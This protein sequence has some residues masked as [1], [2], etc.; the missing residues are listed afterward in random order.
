MKNP[1]LYYGNCKKP[2]EQVREGLFHLLDLDAL[3]VALCLL[4]FRRFSLSFRR[5]VCSGPGLVE[6][7]GERSVVLRPLF[8]PVVSALGLLGVQAAVDHGTARPRDHACGDPARPQPRHRGP[9]LPPLQVV[10]HRFHVREVAEEGRGLHPEDAVQFGVADALPVVRHQFPARRVVVPEGPLPLVEV[11]PGVAQ[12]HQGARLPVQA[13]HVQ[14]LQHGVGVAV[15]EPVVPLVL[16][17]RAVHPHR[18]D[19]VV[20]SLA[21]PQVPDHGFA[22]VHNVA[23][24]VVGVLEAQPVAAGVEAGDR[25]AA[26]L[27]LLHA[28]LRG[29]AHVLGPAHRR[30][31]PLVL[32]A[33]PPPVVQ[34]ARE[35][36]PGQPGVARLQVH[37]AA[38]ELRE[39]LLQQQKP[40]LVAVRLREPRNGRLRERGLGVAGNKI[41]DRD[42]APRGRA[43]R[44]VEQVDA[45]LA[46]HLAL[47]F[48][49]ALRGH[50]VRVLGDHGQRRQQPAVPQPALDAVAGLDP[51]VQ[52]HG[53]VRVVDVARAE[54]LHLALHDLPAARAALGQRLPIR[55][56][57]RVHERLH[58]L[59]Q[60]LLVDQRAVERGK[61]DH[62]LEVLLPRREGREHHL[63]ARL[64]A[65]LHRV[66]LVHDGRPDNLPLP[67]LRVEKHVQPA[68]AAVV[69]G[70][71]QIVLLVGQLL[72][73]AVPRS[74]LRAVLLLLLLALE[75]LP[76]LRGK[77]VLVFL[78][79]RQVQPNHR[80][81]LSELLEHQN[82]GVL[83]KVKLLL[84]DVVLQHELVCRGFVVFPRLQLQFFQLLR[85]CARED[86]HAGLRQKGL[87]RELGVVDPL[88]GSALEGGVLHRV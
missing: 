88:G 65:R 56:E 60:Q 61:L 40:G 38:R 26:E 54:P 43:L 53:E 21:L 74:P 59:L 2:A 16:H 24:L 25:A 85:D 46:V 44:V 7:H 22:R 73:L 45:V 35:R 4:R 6:L 70:K 72:R 69:L 78:D 37:V 15:D 67:L 11:P 10:V 17:P 32:L 57:L 30:G 18:A 49:E 42:R 51:V 3:L 47:F 62:G 75:N 28:L 71:L 58:P 39:R 14:D 19:G 66:R 80:S 1:Q 82:G 76:R 55:G 52:L 29:L 83:G 86:L 34:A 87:H 20:V 13:V 50:E 64:R 77:N 27:H 12:L 41:V 48:V 36:D 5:F 81:W 9:R 84:Q 31:V 33:D 23:G 68:L 63:H 8:L 79:Q